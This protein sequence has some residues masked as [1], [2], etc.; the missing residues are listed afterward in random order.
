MNTTSHSQEIIFLINF[1]QC[2]TKAWYCETASEKTIS[3][4]ER[5]LFLYCWPAKKTKKNV[6]LILSAARCEQRWEY[7][8]DCSSTKLSQSLKFH[9]I[10][11][12]YLFH[13][14]KLYCI[15]FEGKAIMPMLMLLC[16]YIYMTMIPTEQDH[17]TWQ[18]EQQ[19]SRAE[20]QS[21]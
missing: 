16:Y 11:H 17:L 13:F 1:L 5:Q 15:T 14:S 21:H 18:S 7:C 19:L 10:N 12:L 8:D 2:W 20:S 3:S 6:W 4:C 9:F